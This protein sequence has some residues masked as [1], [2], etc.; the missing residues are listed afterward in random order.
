M[1]MGACARTASAED[2]ARARAAGPAHAHARVAARSANAARIARIMVIVAHSPPHKIARRVRLSGC[3]LEWPCACVGRM[4]W[5][6]WAG[7][8]GSTALILL[9]TVLFY[10]FTYKPYTPRAPL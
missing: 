7:V 2:M 9:P 8:A 3:V 5:P 1:Y 4:R 6:W 10:V